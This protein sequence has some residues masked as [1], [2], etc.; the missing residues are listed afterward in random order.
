ME[1]IRSLTL[2]EKPTNVC[3]YT[4][5]VALVAAAKCICIVDINILKNVM[6]LRQTIEF[7]ISITRITACQQ[8]VSLTINTNPSEV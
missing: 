1:Y 8:N 3:M 4:G 7:D 6:S 5:T 2:P